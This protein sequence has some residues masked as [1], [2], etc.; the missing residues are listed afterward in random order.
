MISSDFLSLMA[1][2]DA[3][4]GNSSAAIR[5]A[6]SFH[7]PA[8]NIG[9]RQQGRLRSE[10]VIDVDSDEIGRKREQWIDSWTTTVLR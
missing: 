1:C 10:N 2:A 4:V 5:E 9:S 6:P 8:V 7:L 3:M